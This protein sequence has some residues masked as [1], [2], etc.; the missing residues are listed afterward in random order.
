MEKALICALGER[1]ATK[2]SISMAEH[3]AE[4]RASIPT[5]SSAQAVLWM[6]D[7]IFVIIVAPSRTARG[8]CSGG[9]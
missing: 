5:G 3:T 9:R 4:A 6:T 7:P 1:Y 8:M 2:V